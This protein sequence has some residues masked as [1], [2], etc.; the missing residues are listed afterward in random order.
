MVGPWARL[1]HRREVRG[2]AAG[3]AWALETDPTVLEMGSPVDP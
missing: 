3:M 1:L 2:R